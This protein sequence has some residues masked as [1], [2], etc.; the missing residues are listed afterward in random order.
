MHRT[1]AAIAVVVALM[2]LSARADWQYTKWG[3]TP[4]E[5]VKASN[6]A[7][8]MLAAKDRRKAD[9]TKTEKVAAGSFD[10]GAL[11][12][13]VEFLIDTASGGLVCVAYATK[14]PAQNGLLRQTLIKRYGLPMGASTH[15][16]AAPVDLLGW[17]KPDTIDYQAV[18]GTPASV[19]HC[20]S[21]GPMG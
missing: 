1:F 19:I 16:S 13:E 8:K 3:M 7:M 15:P 20:K 12:L 14:D 10:D 9:L 21:G 4:E 18:P 11:R 17:G 5:A 2:P 6:G